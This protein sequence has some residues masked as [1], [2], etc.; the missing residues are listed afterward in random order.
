LNALGYCFYKTRQKKEALDVLNASLR[1][2]PN[3][4]DVKDL[5]ARV[6][7]ELR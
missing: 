1:L 5:R 4:P 7:K 6:E 3:Q 2:N